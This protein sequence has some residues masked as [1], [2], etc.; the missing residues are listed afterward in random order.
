M[1][2]DLTLIDPS[3]EYEVRP[4]FFS[5]SSNSPFIGRRLRG[6]VRLT[7]AGGKVVFRRRG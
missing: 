5:R 3:A 1:D 7:V 6:A 2:A 4:P